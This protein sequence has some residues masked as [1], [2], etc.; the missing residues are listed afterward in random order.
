MLP[1]APTDTGGEATTLPTAPTATPATTD[2]A[3]PLSFDDS[4]I[5]I[6]GQTVLI[7]RKTITPDELREAAAGDGALVLPDKQVLGTGDILS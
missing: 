6:D 2:A 7:R 4:D 3:E 5:A 1:T